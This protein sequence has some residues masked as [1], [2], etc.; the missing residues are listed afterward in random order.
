MYLSVV[1]MYGAFCHGALKLDLSTLL[2][3]FSTV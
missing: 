1:A 3:F 2:T